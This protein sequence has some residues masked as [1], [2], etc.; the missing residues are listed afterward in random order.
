MQAALTAWTQAIQ[1]QAGNALSAV[2]LYGSAA[3]KESLDKYS[4]LNLLVV[5]KQADLEQ[6]AEIDEA[7]RKHLRGLRAS[8]VFWAEAELK[9]A[10]DVFAL[11]FADIQAS[12]QCLLGKDPFRGRRADKKNL[13]FQLEF[14]LRSKLLAL[15]SNWLRFRNDRQALELY[16]RQAGKSLAYLIRQGQAVFPKLKAL[17]PQAWQELTRLRESNVRPGKPELKRM[18]LALHEALSGAVRIIDAA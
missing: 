14:E 13:R 18:F 2:I 1:T 11:E 8:L 10:W 6:M 9:R 4:D 3:R 7:T 16:L 5:L 17:P 12:H 15:R